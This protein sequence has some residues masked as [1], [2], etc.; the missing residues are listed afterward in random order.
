MKSKWF[1]RTRALFPA[2]LLL[3]SG[4]AVRAE[5]LPPLIPKEVMFGDPE[6]SHPELSPDGTQ[7]AWLAPDK[8][9]VV[10]VWVGAS[11]GSDAR[12]VTNESHRPIQWY[13]WAGDGKHILY[14]QDNAGDEVD[15]L[16]PL[17]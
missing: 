3:L 8:N 1:G 7:L 9:G 6:R 17:T 4:G 12:A 5:E 16:F 14:L 11:N 15:H 10:N 13:A 2:A